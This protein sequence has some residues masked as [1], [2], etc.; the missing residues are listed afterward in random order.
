M[1]GPLPRERVAE[2]RVRDLSE[3]ETPSSALRAPSP[4]GRRPSI[5]ISLTPEHLG[6]EFLR[7]VPRTAPRCR[8]I[9]QDFLCLLL[10]IALDIQQRDGRDARRLQRRFNG[11]AIADDHD[12]KMIHVDVLLSDTDEVFLLNI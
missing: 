4:E 12:R 2:G 6:S 1:E 7:K 10:R 3:P 8:P 11:R 5:Q 9:T